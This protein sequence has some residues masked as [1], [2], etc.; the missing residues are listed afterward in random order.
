M[1][2]AF[3]LVSVLT[4][5]T[6]TVFQLHRLTQFNQIDEQLER[7]VAALSRDVRSGPAPGEP[8]VETRLVCVFVT[9]RAA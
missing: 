4:G 8:M 3:L 5:F 9:K 1:W 6:V 7:C 2:L